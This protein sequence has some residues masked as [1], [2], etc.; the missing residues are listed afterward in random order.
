MFFPVSRSSVCLPFDVFVHPDGKLRQSGNDACCN[1]FMAL[2]W[3]LKDAILNG[4]FG[5]P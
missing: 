2:K 1:G 5:R 4:G 3:A